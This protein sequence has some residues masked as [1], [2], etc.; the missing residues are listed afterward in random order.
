MP[1]AGF[2]V[3]AV[4]VLLL[5][6]V[7]APCFSRGSEAFQAS[8]QRKHNVLR[9][10]AAGFFGARGINV[11]LGHARRAARTPHFFTS[12]VTWE[13]R[14]I[15]QSIPLCDLLDVLRQDRAKQRYEMHEFVFMR[16]HVHL[17]LT[18][19]P[20]VSLEK[21]MQFVKGGLSYRA[22]KELN[23]N[24]E[25]WEKGY[26]EHRIRD[27]ADYDQHVD[28]VW[29]NPVKAGLAERPEDY[30]YSSARLRDEVDPPPLQFRRRGQRPA[31]KAA[32][33]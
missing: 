14:F 7:G 15:L 17:I 31:A 13:R 23:F 27:A 33:N 9:L 24:R 5:V 32:K 10:S 16:D 21:A 19:A 1:I 2:P 12:F 28:Y 6:L 30:L 8:R 26:N 4:V 18:P 22:K 20:L 3:F 25:I 29:N 11:A